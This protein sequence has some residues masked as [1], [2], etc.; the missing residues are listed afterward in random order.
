[1]IK[2]WDEG[3]DKKTGKRIVLRI[4]HKQ[5]A[6]IDLLYTLSPSRLNRF[7]ASRIDYVVPRGLA[8]DEGSI[9]DT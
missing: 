2:L 3:D 7:L 6:L 8:R 5:A 9:E 1:M 4:K